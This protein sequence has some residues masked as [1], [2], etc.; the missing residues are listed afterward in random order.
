MKKAQLKSIFLFTLMF[1]VSVALISA[2]SITL[3]SPDAEWITTSSVNFNFTPTGTDI[4][5][6]FDWCGIYINRT[7]GMILEANYSD[8]PNATAFVRG[9]A[10]NDS[11][12][13]TFVWNVSCSN[14]TEV[15][16][17]TTSSY[18]GVDS[19]LPTITLDEPID[20]IYLSGVTDFLRY[21]PVDVT[22]ADTCLLYSNLSNTWAVNQTN[23]SY[24]SSTQ[25]QMQASAVDG[26]YIWNANC[27]QSSSDIVW[28]EDTNRTFTIDTLSPGTVNITDPVNNTFSDDSTPQITWNKTS[29]I[30]FDKYVINLSNSSDMAF[31]IQSIEITSI[32]GNSTTLANIETDGEYF[33]S[34][35]SHDLA[36]NAQSGNYVL[37]YNLDSDTGIVAVSA[38]TDTSYLSSNDVEFNFT[39]TD[40]N[41]SN[42]TLLLSNSTALTS[43]NVVY[44]NTSITVTAGTV[45]NITVPD[46]IDGG[47]K[48]NIECAD[49]NNLKYNMSPTLLNVTVDTLNP[50]FPNLTM[51]LGLVNSTDGTP[52][53]NWTQADDNNFAKYV[54]SALNLSNAA[55]I[56]QVNISAIGTLFTTLTLPFE[57]NYYFNVTAYDLAGNTNSAWNTTGEST[58]YIDSI[59]ANLTAGWNL[60]G[61]V[62][63][64][65]KN[66]STVAAEMDATFIS[67]WNETKQWQTC[68]YV[69]GEGGTNCDRMVGVSDSTNN[70]THVW[71]YVNSSTLWEDRV[72]DANK[73]SANFT[74]TNQSN[75]GW[76]IL[77]MVARNG[78]TFESLND[79]TRL[80]DNA[81]MYSLPYNNGTSI[82]YVTIDGF[83]SINKDTQVDYGRAMWV[84]KNSSDT[85]EVNFDL[86]VW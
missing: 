65:Q 78:R 7:A 1:L 76:N 70:A 43:A 85:S 28:A 59:C 16:S 38:P 68:N 42:C 15:V 3:N 12:G 62:R 48:W 69:L 75:N 8:V 24:V 67:I 61:L 58:I 26:R 31:V 25:I 79:T 39:V 80:G 46:M 86:G 50:G 82:P 71:I 14:G 10:L 49:S 64:A 20:D 17:A 21:T 54:I 72:W 52:T 36:G 74:L 30:N 35:S 11:I 47:Y 41:P 22:N 77:S 40:D 13:T 19:N 6:P 32:S 9:I 33:I 34:V 18:F 83:N 45:L 66:L 81:S 29:D 84:F 73:F 57:G 60:C 51:S 4:V 23:S 55:L 5:D 63:E 37:Q 53:V 27:N 56:S 44:V 2:L